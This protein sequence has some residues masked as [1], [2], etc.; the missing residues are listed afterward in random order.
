MQRSHLIDRLAKSDEPSVR[1]KVRIGVLD[2]DPGSRSIRRL[3][4]E[5]RDGARVRSLLARRDADGRIRTRRDVYD[6]WHGAHWVFAALADLGYPAG[7]ETL[8]PLRDQVFAHWLQAQFYEEFDATSRQQAYRRSGVPRM[9]GRYRRCGSQ[10]GNALL[11]A[12][13]L[14]LLDDQAARLVERLLHWQW[15]DGGWNCDKNPSADTS[16]FNETLLPM[17]G[18]ALYGRIR[19]DTNAG[20]A[21]RSAAEVFLSRRLFKRRSDGAVISPGFVA[22]H[23]PAYWHYDILG[24]LKAMAELDLIGA[25]RCSEA[26]DLLESRELQGS[27]WTADERYFKPSA[28]LAHGADYVDWGGTSR[29]TP[30]EWITADALC[31]LHAAG[32]V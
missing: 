6:K 30:N 13:K 11:A 15:P 25:Q 23:Y 21:A 17:R 26:L 3:Q 18:L 9:Q 2:E 16:S 29:K 27:G 31:V 14:G 8:L 19:K 1:W 7:D 24:G 22:L 10:Q 32:R 4:N 12:G 5:I 28:E 20:T